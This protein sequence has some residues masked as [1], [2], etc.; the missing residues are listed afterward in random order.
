MM[1]HYCAGIICIWLT[2]TSLRYLFRPRLIQCPSPLPSGPQFHL[3]CHT[4][5]N[6]LL[7]PVNLV[8]TNWMSVL[9]LPPFWLAAGWITSSSLVIPLGDLMIGN[10]RQFIIRV[11]FVRFTPRI[12]RDFRG[13]FSFS[14]WMGVFEF[15]NKCA[16][17]RKSFSQT[18]L[19]SRT[20]IGTHT[21]AEPI[22]SIKPNN[23]I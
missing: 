10:R 11:T 7:F 8:L 4:T 3:L 21:A 2:L 14:P 22:L 23:Y 17:S 20:L 18:A 19:M 12:F 5:P 1:R 9:L 15:V 16:N 6:L 13:N